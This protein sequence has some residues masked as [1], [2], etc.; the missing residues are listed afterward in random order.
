MVGTHGLLGICQ[1]RLRLESALEVGAVFPLDQIFG[2]SVTLPMRQDF[3]DPK[4]VRLQ[5][6]RQMFAESSI[7][8]L[9]VRELENIDTSGFL[10]HGEPLPPGV[11][12]A[13][14]VYDDLVVMLMARG[15]DVLNN[16]ECKEIF[17]SALTPRP[18]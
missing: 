12:W 2:G 3:V 4:V 16:G 7:L 15:A 9:R 6:R 13:G 10:A 8:R 18:T 5:C 1:I 14:A 11:L 17:E